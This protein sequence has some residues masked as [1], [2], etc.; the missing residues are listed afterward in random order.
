MIYFTLSAF[1]F[2]MG[3]IGYEGLGTISA[4]ISGRDMTYG[5]YVMIEELFEMIG[6]IGFI[7]TFSDY[8][9]NKDISINLHFM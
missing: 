9:S 3:A 5:L 7:Y 6:V 2:L 1:I 4:N 8:I